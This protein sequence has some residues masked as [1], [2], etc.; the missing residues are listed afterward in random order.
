L[1]NKYKI[2]YRTIRDRAIRE[3]WAKS[4]AEYQSKVR[5]KTEQKTIEK[6]SNDIANT[7]AK[8][9]K[10]SNDF[11]H[12]VENAL[13]NKDEFNTF[14]DKVKEGSKDYFSEEV[15]EFILESVNDKKVLNMVSAFE[16]IQKAQR[17]ILGITDIK[18]NINVDIKQREFEHKKFMDEERLKIQREELEYRKWLEKEKLKKDEINIDE[19]D[20]GFIEALG[21]ATE[22]VWKDVEFEDKEEE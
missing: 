16:K 2:P 8:H 4:K 20:D 12:I 1:A 13:N 17:Q 11:L 19:E 6:I 21:I 10:L 9:F 14:V 3:K 7:Q 22:E 15:R 18:E 5:A